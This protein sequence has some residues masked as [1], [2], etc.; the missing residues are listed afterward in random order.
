MSPGHRFIHWYPSTFY[1]VLSFLAKNWVGNLAPILPQ[2]QTEE[3]IFITYM[4]FVSS[5]AL[6]R[7]VTDILGGILIDRY[8]GN[9]LTSVGMSIVV[10]YIQTKL[11]L[12]GRDCVIAFV[13]LFGL[14]IIAARNT[15]RWIFG[16]PPRTITIPTTASTYFPNS[17]CTHGSLGKCS[18]PG[19]TFADAEGSLLLPS[20]PQDGAGSLRS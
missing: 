10:V 9:F 13:I 8:G 4:V 17:L 12:L 19:N 14:L 2:I 15:C 7:V 1:M 5:F 6:A 20:L 18:I 16:S 11:L 3:G